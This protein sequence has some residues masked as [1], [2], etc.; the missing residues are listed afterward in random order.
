MSVTEEQKQDNVT[1]WNNAIVHWVTIVTVFVNVGVVIL[2][3][4]FIEPSEIPLK[5]QY[6]V[7]FGTSLSAPWWQAY[8][9][10]LMGVIFFVIDLLIGYVLYNAKE[11]VA[12]YIVLLGSLF[13][14]VALVIASISIV[15]NNSSV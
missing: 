13:A 3:M 9:L 10:P 4:V 15:I 11:R 7:F 2:F 8:L 6:N 1:Y 12:S 5:L 14:S